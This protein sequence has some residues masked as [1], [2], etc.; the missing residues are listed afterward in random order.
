METSWSA[1]IVTVD[2]TL[3][4]EPL[5]V[6]TRTKTYEPETSAVNVGLTTR[7]ENKVAKL[8]RPGDHRPRIGDRIAVRVM[9][10]LP[11]RVTVAPVATF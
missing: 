1:L 2:G 11:S 8:R 9:A 5:S 3:T 7:G 6:T 4:A 10:P